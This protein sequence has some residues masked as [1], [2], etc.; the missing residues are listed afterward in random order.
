[1]RV[2]TLPTWSA[3]DLHDAHRNRRMETGSTAAVTAPGGRRDDS[4]L[5]PSEAKDIHICCK[6]L[7][8]SDKTTTDNNVS[9]IVIQRV[10]KCSPTLLPPHGV[11]KMG[12][13]VVCY[14]DPHIWNCF[15]SF[16]LLEP[17]STALCL[18]TSEQSQYDCYSS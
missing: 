16:V 8:T 10:S 12:H 5:E 6:P 1:M 14:S 13:A 9:S 15:A 11:S 18:S 17:L 2:W 7:F 3:S 4:L